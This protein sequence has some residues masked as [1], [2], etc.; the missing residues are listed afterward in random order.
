MTGGHL[1]VISLLL[2]IQGEHAIFAKALGQG[3]ARS[4]IYFP[5]PV[6]EQMIKDAI[7]YTIN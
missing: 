1:L 5:I 3:L 2:L 6:Q 4:F 7:A